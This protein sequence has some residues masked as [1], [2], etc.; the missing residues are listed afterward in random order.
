MPGPT[1]LLTTAGPTH[2]TRDSFQ[3]LKQK[4]V[5]ANKEFY[6]LVSNDIMQNEQA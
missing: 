6:S 1:S 3:H 2:H 4:N 5:S